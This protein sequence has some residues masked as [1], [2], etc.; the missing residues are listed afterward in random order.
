[1]ESQL[2]I[3]ERQ[4]GVFVVHKILIVIL[5][6]ALLTACGFGSDDTYIYDSYTYDTD[7]LDENSVAI[8]PITFEDTSLVKRR[9][10]FTT[11][12]QVGERHYFFPTSD[13]AVN[14]YFIAHIEQFIGE[15]EHIMPFLFFT[16]E[17]LSIYLA[18]STS[19]YRLN[20][21]RDAPNEVSVNHDDINTFGWLTHVWSDGK[22]PIWISSGIESV[23]LSNLGWHRFD[24]ENMSGLSDIYFAPISWGSHEQRQATNTAYNFIRHLIGINYIESLVELYM[25]ENRTAAEKMASELF[26]DFNGHE[27]DNFF[28]LEFYS[29]L[30]LHAYNIR[31]YTDMGNYSF[32]FRSFDEKLEVDLMRLYLALSDDAIAFTKNWYDRY[33][34]FYYRFQPLNVILDYNPLGRTIDGF[35]TGGRVTGSNEF[36]MYGIALSYGTILHYIP[37]E[38]AHLLTAMGGGAQHFHYEGLA[39]VLTIYYAT[40]DSKG[41]GFMRQI[42]QHFNLDPTTLTIEQIERGFQFVA[43]Y[44]IYG[45][46]DI[47]MYLLN[48][49]AAEN[50]DF[51]AMNLR[52]YAVRH[53]EEN[54]V[55]LTERHGYWNPAS[56]WSNHR[57][58]DFSRITLFG[59]SVS[60]I[61][62]L[63]ESY[64]AEA[65][66]RVH[67]G[68]DFEYVYGI[69][70]D[71]MI[72]RWEIFLENLVDEMRLKAKEALN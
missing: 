18:D 20:F 67:F 7:S 10:G 8:T 9:A 28:R 22:L 59:E 32:V 50:K 15:L 14:T 54:L 27:L 37:H 65:Y 2:Y 21:F 47:V 42:L 49:I 45:N 57:N 71:K 66:M 46:R 58:P 62:Y 70:P 24:D 31:V 52:A 13:A 53:H 72:D 3:V 23:A 12:A 33:T 55:H 4:K 16:S 19:N 41:Y 38:V 6:V 60:F 25:T 39:S 51:L 17:P 35:S 34:D 30:N 64:G 40:H 68:A 69:T 56:F 48:Y 36:T 29:P 5:S 43:M 1:M 44:E 26:W 63:I 11:T 61:Y